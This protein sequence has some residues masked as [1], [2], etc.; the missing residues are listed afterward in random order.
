M[1]SKS[2][3]QRSLTTLARPSNHD[4]G[5]IDEGGL[6]L[7]DGEPRKKLGVRFVQFGSLLRPSRIIL[8]SVSDYIHVRFGLQ[9]RPVRIVH[10]LELALRASVG[11]DSDAKRAYKN[12][13]KSLPVTLSI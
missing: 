3:Y 5:R 9:A 2:P 13:Y 10:R 6:H 11:D 8:T 1:T 4:G 12:A 7:I